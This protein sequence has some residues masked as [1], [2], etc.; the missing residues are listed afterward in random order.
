MGA[1][2]GARR[3]SAE[4]DHQQNNEPDPATIRDDVRRNNALNEVSID[5][6][7]GAVTIRV[8]YKLAPGTSA[9]FESSF[10]SEVESSLSGYRVSPNFASVASVTVHLYSSSTNPAFTLAECGTTTCSRPTIMGGWTNS[11]K[12]MEIRSTAPFGT[13]THEFL[14][15]LGLGHQW[16]ITNSIMSYSAHRQVQYMDIHRIQQAYGN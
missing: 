12:L 5:P 6:I 2:M 15:F 1:M 7:T 14:H 16:N 8:P 4:Q 11:T 3:S 13:R 10:I 9:E